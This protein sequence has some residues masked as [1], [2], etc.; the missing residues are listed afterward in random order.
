MNLKKKFL[1]DYYDYAKYKLFPICRSLTGD[2]NKKTLNLIKKKLNFL[3]LK[4]FNLDQKFMIGEF[5]L[6]GTL[7]QRV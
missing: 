3:R 1:R 7:N 5:H 4:V 2:G 6:N